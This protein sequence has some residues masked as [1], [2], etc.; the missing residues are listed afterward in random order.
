MGFLREPHGDMR[1]IELREIFTE[2]F[3][4]V[5]PEAHRLGESHEIPWAA[6]RE[7]PF[8]LFPR[9]VAPGLYDLLTTACVS[10][11]FTLTIVQEAQSWLGIVA[12]VATELGVSFAPASFQRLAWEGVR[13]CHLTPNPPVTTT[14]LAYRTNP[15]PTVARFVATAE[16]L[17]PRETSTSPL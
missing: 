13:Y 12:L 14:H 17:V 2:E 15:T 6:V 11:G 8:V 7:E 4:L 5:V 3:V 1:G 16:G 10:A 9:K